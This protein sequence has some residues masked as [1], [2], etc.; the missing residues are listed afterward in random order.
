MTAPATTEGEKKRDYGLDIQDTSNR[1]RFYRF[2]VR[3]DTGLVE[4]RPGNLD[5]VIDAVPLDLVFLYTVGQD[6]MFRVNQLHLASI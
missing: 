5:S 1:I 4:D 6:S 3:R 2:I